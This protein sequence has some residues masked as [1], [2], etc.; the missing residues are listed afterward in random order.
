MKKITVSILTTLLMLSMVFS[1]SVFAAEKE[2]S[3]WDSFLGLFSAKTAATSDV[4]VEYRGHIQNVG[5]Y[6]LDG[7]WIQGPT[8]L[9][10][11]GKGLRL[12]GFWIQLDG[13]VPAD[14]HIEYQ[15]HVQ[16]V[17]WMDPVQDGEFAGTEGRSL[18]IEAIKISLVDD[19]G[20]LLKD[21]SVVYSGHVQ[22]VGDVG[23]YTNGEDR[24]SVV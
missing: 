24:K 5:N 7:S 20:E 9:G 12:E 15:V 10:T 18:Q 11:E 13:D 17:G 19:E 2:Q 14:A 3:A 6:P 23:P 1:S 8:E 22:N 4:G 16:N 21:Y